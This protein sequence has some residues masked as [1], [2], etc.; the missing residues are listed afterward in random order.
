MRIIGGRSWSASSMTSSDSRPVPERGSFMRRAELGEQARLASLLE[1]LHDRLEDHEAHPRQALELLVAV[2]A[3]V[4]V[5]L[6]EALEPDALG[7]VDEVADL[8]RVA[9]EERDR[10]EQRRAGRRTRPASGWM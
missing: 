2:D 9:G 8:D 7:E 4:E 3:D 1:P 5:D 6:A 10:L